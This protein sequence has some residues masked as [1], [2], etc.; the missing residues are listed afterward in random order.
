MARVVT[1]SDD[2]LSRV[3]K[4]IPTEI[5]MAYVSIEGVLYATYSPGVPRERELLLKLLWGVTAAL[6]IL[7]P[8]WLWR[9]MR[10]KRFEQLLISTLSVPVWLFALGGPFTLQAWY[11]P[12]FG[13]IV[14]PLY[15]LVVPIISRSTLR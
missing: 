1:T 14:L 3:L 15:T 9:V 7:T 13:A 8:L 12:A 2:Y 4:H 5:V 6:T 11:E 10:V